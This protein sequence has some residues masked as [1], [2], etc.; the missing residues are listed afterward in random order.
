MILYEHRQQAGS[1]NLLILKL[2]KSGDTQK[3]MT[4]F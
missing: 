2:N 1:L 4:F 3:Q